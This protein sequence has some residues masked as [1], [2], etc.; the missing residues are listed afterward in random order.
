MKGTKDNIIDHYESTQRFYSKESMSMHCGLWDDTVSNQTEANLN[1]NKKVAESI[2][3]SSHDYVLDAGCGV[4]GSAVY[5]AKSYGCNVVGITLL[6][7]Q[8][9]KAKKFA[10]KSGVSKLTEFHVGDFTATNFEDN[11][12]DKIYSIECVCHSV[13]KS[14]YLNEMYRILKPGGKIAILDAYLLFPATQMTSS[15]KAIYQEFLEGFFLDNLAE[16]SVFRKQLENSGFTNVQHIDYTEQVQKSTKQYYSDTS[17]WLQFF[18]FLEKIKLAPRHWVGFVR[19][20]RYTHLLVGD[21]LERNICEYGLFTG[22][23]TK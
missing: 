17:F 23:K 8:V 6:D 19:S 21:T 16:A 11:T 18:R 9:Q 3:I 13:D 12:F 5:M 22:T 20:V 2:N 14:D 1:T 10:E 15:E 4:G 7:M